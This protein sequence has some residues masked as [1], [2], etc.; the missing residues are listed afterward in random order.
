MSL[1]LT[2]SAETQ[3]RDATELPPPYATPATTRELLVTLESIVCT[4]PYSPDIDALVGDNLCAANGPGVHF[5]SLEVLQAG[6]DACLKLI[7]VDLFEFGRSF[8]VQRGA[9]S[10]S[11]PQEYRL[12]TNPRGALNPCGPV[13]TNG[14]IHVGTRPTTDP[15]LSAPVAGESSG[16]H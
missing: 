3:D 5:S 15:L 9:A 8:Q 1:N 6:Q 13:T 10:P 7:G 14:T 12:V 16:E 11:S 2:M 4:N